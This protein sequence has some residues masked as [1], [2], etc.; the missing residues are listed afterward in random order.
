MVWLMEALK[1]K[2]NETTKEKKL[3]TKVEKSEKKEE[4]VRE[5]EI[6]CPICG[7]KEVVKDYERAEIVCAKCGCVIKEKLFDIGPEWRAFDHEQKIKRCRVG[8]PMTY[9]VDYNEPIIIK[10]NG[11]IKVV[12]IGELID[13]IIE[14]SENIRREG[15]LEIAKCKGIEVI[16]FNSNYKFKFMPVSEVSRHPVSE[17]F[18]IV[19]EGNKKVRVTRS[20]SVFTIR[21]NEVVPIRVDELKVGDILVLAKELPNIEEDIEIDKKFSKILGYIIAEGYYDDKKIVLSY[22]YNEKEFINETIDYFKSLNSDITIYSKDLNIQIEVK[23]KKIINLLKKLRVKNKRIPSIIFKSPYEIKKSFIDGIFNGK[24]AKVF[25]SKELAEDVIFLL[26]QIKE[27]ATIN[28]K[29]INDIEVYEVRRITNIYTNR[30]LEKLINSDFI[31]LKIKEINKV[32]PTSGY[33][34]DLTVPNAENFVAGFGGFVLH[35]TIHDKGLS[36][37]IDWRNKDSY[38][39]DLSANK[40]AQLYRLRKWQ[41]RIRVSDAAERNLAFALSELDRIT[42]K[43]GLPRHVR[44]NAA[45]IYRGAVEK[46]LIRGRSIE[47]VVAAAIYAACRR[48]RVPRTLDEIAEASRVDRKEIGRTYRFLARELNIKLTPT[49]PIDYVPRFASELGLPGEVESKAIQILQQAAEKGLTSGRGPTGV[50][51]AA[52][53]IASVLLGCR[54]TQRE[55]AE[56]AGVTEVTI[57]NRYKELTEH[58]DIDVTL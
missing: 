5:E 27:N 35:N 21:D 47:G 58:L 13:K 30:K 36:T 52:I 14:N 3:T 54:R 45:I 38:G 22:D 49:N 15:I 20:H 11:E 50:A 1:T 33:A 53:Y 24:D 31:F 48:C 51:A 12:K 2:E 41:R 9:S 6:V 40:R 4:N 34:Y 55:V 43:L 42:S 17:M 46:G 23:N 19:V 32:E 39:K 56:V 44:E 10:E 26:L 57:R 8:A 28:K 16:A 18:E 37:V 29:S 25:V 7:S